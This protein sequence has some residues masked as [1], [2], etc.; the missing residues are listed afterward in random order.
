[1]IVDR[2]LHDPRMTLR[3]RFSTD[4][5]GSAGTIAG[6]IPAPEKPDGKRVVEVALPADGFV[7]F[8]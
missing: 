2:D 1:V 5:A 6:A 4:A 8:R 3:C 7:V